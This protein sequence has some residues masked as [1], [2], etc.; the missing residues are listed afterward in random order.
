M[1]SFLHNREVNLIAIDNNFG[2]VME[3]AFSEDLKNSNEITAEAWAQRPLVDHFREWWAR[4][5]GYWL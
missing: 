5:F 1:R 4:R 2:S 3:D